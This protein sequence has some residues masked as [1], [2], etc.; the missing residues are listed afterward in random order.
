MDVVQSPFP[1]SKTAATRPL[2]IERALKSGMLTIIQY[3]ISYI[4]C[5][6]HHHRP[7]KYNSYLSDRA[8]GVVLL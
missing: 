6:L 1:H 5:S 4:E 3:I 2:P 8:G 7:K